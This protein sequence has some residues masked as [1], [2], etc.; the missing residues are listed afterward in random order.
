MSATTEN[1]IRAIQ[2]NDS[3]AFY[4]WLQV[5]KGTPD[6]D[7]GVA[8]DP[9]VTPLAVAAV[10][11][12]K[13]VKS[14]PHQAGGYANMVSA[15]IENG[16]NPLVRIGDRYAIK[17]CSDGRLAQ[18]RVVE[19]QTLAEACGGVLAPAMQAFFKKQQVGD[20]QNASLHRKHPAY[21]TKAEAE[22]EAE[23]A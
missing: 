8:G 20:W 17:R 1:L 16:A 14:D 21:V 7:A 19:G 23:A 9:G 10:M 22:A 11:Y 18:R 4:G 3:L 13:V 6:L 2:T 12:S 5:L 15:L